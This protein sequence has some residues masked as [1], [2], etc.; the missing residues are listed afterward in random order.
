MTQLH[1]LAWKKLRLMSLSL[2]RVFIFTQNYGDYKIVPVFYSL[3][4]IVTSDLRQRVH[5]LMTLPLPATAIGEFKKFWEIGASVITW[6]TVNVN[7]AT[8]Q[9]QLRAR[10]NTRGQ[11]RGCALPQYFWRLIGNSLETKFRFIHDICGYFLKAGYKND[12]FVLES[13]TTKRP[14]STH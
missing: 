2:L 3:M 14:N 13:P 4:P 11:S 12:F 1:K 9:S 7:N 10:I 5:K 6:L 8:D